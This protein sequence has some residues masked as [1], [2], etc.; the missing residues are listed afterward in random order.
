[1]SRS[2]RTRTSAAASCS[3]ATPRQLAL[4]PSSLPATQP[5]FDAR[6][7]CSVIAILL[8]ALG[9]DA[10]AFETVL[11]PIPAFRAVGPKQ[12]SYL[13]TAV[14][15]GGDVDGDGF[16][17]ILISEQA[18]VGLSRVLCRFGSNSGIAAGDEQSIPSYFDTPYFGAA[19]A[20]AGDANGD[21]FADAVISSSD[22][23]EYSS[24]S[25]GEVM[26]CAVYYGSPSGLPTTPSA[27]LDSTFPVA[28]FG[29]DVEYVGDVNGDGVDDIVVG[30]PAIHDDWDWDGSVALYLGSTA[31]VASQPAWVAVD[32]YEY[33]R[34]GYSIASAGDLNLDGLCDV[35]FLLQGYDEHGKVIAYGGALGGLTSQ[36]IWESGGTADGALEFVDAIVAGG[37]DLDGNG[38]LDLAVSCPKFGSVDGQTLIYLGAPQGM[39][40][41]ASSS[42]DSDTH[43]EEEVPGSL[44]ILQDQNDDGFDELLIGNPSYSLAQEY[45]GRIEC[46]RGS[47]TGP[48]ESPDWV[49]ERNRS[50]GFGGTVANA[51]D[52]NG[53]GRPEFV[54]GAN[55]FSSAGQS[56]VKYAFGE[57]IVF[58][59]FVETTPFTPGD[60]LHANL[61]NPGDAAFGRFLALRG[62]KLRLTLVSASAGGSITVSLRDSAGVVRSV[63]S[64]VASPSNDE[65]A[66]ALDAIG[67]FVLEIASTSG[68]PIDCEFQTERIL[69]G[70]AKPNQHASIIVKNPK[71]KYEWLSVQALPG[72]QMDVFLTRKHAAGAVLSSTHLSTRSPWSGFIDLVPYTVIEEDGSAS[73]LDVPISSANEY[74]YGFGGWSP[75]SNRF[76]CQIVLT[77]PPQGDALVELVVGEQP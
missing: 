73:I 6:N 47:A 43:G 60:R 44:C 46:Y 19:L 54:V 39:P 16:S 70:N 69:P 49:I 8:L 20:V 62:M 57:Y 75:K 11:Q 51:G 12:F 67:E 30:A 29:F 50:A 14:A 77:Q 9:A 53:D 42:I 26:H 37:G 74:E 22:S 2:T 33:I 32:D 15:G 72:A 64:F 25:S 65:H 68:A 13:G 59:R 56:K 34:L 24:Y 45:E 36:P 27:L 10:P 58:D 71:T 38:I 63:K 17:D 5:P 61:L 48:S 7:T 35:A 40:T 1:M 31:G 18:D 52:L 55:Q 3:F 66:F 21:G 23:S 76:D 28:D 4:G 41:I